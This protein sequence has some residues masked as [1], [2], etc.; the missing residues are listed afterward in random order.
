MMSG[1]QADAFILLN[2]IAIYFHMEW[3]GINLI[4]CK[5]SSNILGRL[6]GRKAN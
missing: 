5:Y 6:R 2:P 3:F 4:D 1:R